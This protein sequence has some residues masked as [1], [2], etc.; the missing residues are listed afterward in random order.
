[1]FKKLKW[2]LQ[3]RFR[4]WADCD[5]WDMDYHLA[6]LILP[7]IRAY[8]DFKKENSAGYPANLTE[9]DW[10][11]ILDK[12]VDGFELF[13]ECEIGD[14]LWEYAQPKIEGGLK[15]FGRWFGHFWD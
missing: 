8:R 12:I 2:F 9:K 14:D 10:N 6:K 13:L 5:L 3:R 1:M 7:R 15:L 4:G 11:E